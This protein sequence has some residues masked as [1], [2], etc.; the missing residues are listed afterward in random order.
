[1]AT[2]ND[3]PKIEGIRDFF[4]GEIYGEISNML[5]RRGIFGDRSNLLYVQSLEILADANALIDIV[6]DE[7]LSPEEKDARIEASVCDLHRRLAEVRA[8]LC[9]E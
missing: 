5:S 8:A 7:A 4:R 6:L 2:I 3:L 9:G 1:M